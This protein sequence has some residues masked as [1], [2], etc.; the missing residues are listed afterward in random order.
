MLPD[1]VRCHDWGYD[2]CFEQNPV[3]PA[4][5]LIRSHMLADW[6][7][8]YGSEFERQKRGW[9]YRKMG[10]YAKT[11]EAFQ[12]EAV[13]RKLREDI[14]M[15]DSRR[16]F[17]HTMIEY[18]IDTWLANRGLV[19]DRFAFLK[20]TY[21][22]L[23]KSEGPGSLEAIA[24]VIQQEGIDLVNEKM[25]QDVLSFGRRVEQSKSP[26]EF[27]YRAGVKKFGLDDTDDAV[28]FVGEFIEHGLKQ[29]DDAE[30]EQFVDDCVSFLKQWM[31]ST[32]HAEAE[33]SAQWN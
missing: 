6:F 33:E 15:N 12:A 25:G 21:A 13:R 31:G 1:Y 24:R 9:A 10:V 29:I 14:P 18:S 28:A 30:I 3:T 26:V 7:V 19:D 22:Q 11:Y 4:G 27:A 32:R 20:E 17:S 5:R 8:H 2:K 16:G 23:G